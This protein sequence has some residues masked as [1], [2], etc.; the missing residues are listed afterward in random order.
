MWIV[1]D[2]V[3][4]DGVHRTIVQCIQERNG[5]HKTTESFFFSFVSY[6]DFVRAFFVHFSIHEA[7]L[8]KKSVQFHI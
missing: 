4:E 8:N 3:R 5:L 2:Y 1:V 7:S 6:L